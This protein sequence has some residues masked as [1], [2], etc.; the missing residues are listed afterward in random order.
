MDISVVIP[1]YNEEESLKELHDRIRKVMQDNDYSYEIIFVDDG[2]TITHGKL[3]HSSEM[4]RKRLKLLSL[5]AIMV[6]LLLCIVHLK[7]L[8]AK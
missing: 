6:S 3:L 2:S 4:K 1:L 5:D 7:R 8:W